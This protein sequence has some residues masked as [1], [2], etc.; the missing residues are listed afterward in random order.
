MQS[1]LAYFSV[2]N[3]FFFQF[4]KLK[5]LKSYH[6]QESTECN[7]AKYSKI[8]C[9]NKIFFSIFLN[10]IRCRCRLSLEADDDGNAEENLQMNST[11]FI[12]T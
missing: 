4:K 9:L 12:R 3:Q 11:M 10:W 2:Q 7:V 6:W 1:F 8:S 5:W